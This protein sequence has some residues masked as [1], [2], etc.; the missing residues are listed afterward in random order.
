MRRIIMTTCFLSLIIFS[1][2]SSC[3]AQN[4]ENE[5]T[6]EIVSDYT[7]TIAPSDSP[8]DRAK[9]RRVE[10]VLVMEGKKQNVK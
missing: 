5:D 6:I 10:I 4:D 7:Y 9:N 2:H 8:A 1:V 3:L